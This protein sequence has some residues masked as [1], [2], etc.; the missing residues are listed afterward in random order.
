MILRLPIS[1]TAVQQCLCSE[2]GAMALQWACAGAVALLEQNNVALCVRP[3]LEMRCI[4]CL[5]MQLCRC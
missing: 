3:A 1:R 2:V 5:S 4:L